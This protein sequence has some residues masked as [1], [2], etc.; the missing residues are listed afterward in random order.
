MGFLPPAFYLLRKQPPLT[1]VGA[2]LGG[3]QPSGLQDHRK[4]VGGAPALRILL[5]CRHHFSLLPTGLPLVV[6]GDNVN[7][8]LR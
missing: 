4:L 2:A 1:A 7:S 8:Q 3:V 6:E 5:G